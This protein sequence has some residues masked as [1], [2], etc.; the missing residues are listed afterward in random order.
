MKNFFKEFFWQGKLLFLMKT[1]V[2][3]ILVWPIKFQLTDSTVLYIPLLLRISENSFMVEPFLKINIELSLGL[4]AQYFI[5]LS[6]FF[7]IS[8]FLINHPRWLFW[9]TAS[10][11]IITIKSFIVSSDS[12][13]SSGGGGLAPAVC[14]ASFKFFSIN[15]TFYLFLILTV[16]SLILIIVSR[17]KSSSVTHSTAVFP[18]GNE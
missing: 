11:I 6:L 9:T 4:F 10:L 7:L 3:I 12:C 5:Y 13:G 15:S 18:Q 2:S 16:I 14:T 1:I 17:L 8:K